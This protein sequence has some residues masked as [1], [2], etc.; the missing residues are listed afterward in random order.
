MRPISDLHYR[1]PIRP[2]APIERT[3][4]IEPPGSGRLHSFELRRRI[5]GAGEWSEAEIGGAAAQGIGSPRLGM[6]DVAAG[7]AQPSRGGGD[8]GGQ[9][10]EGEEAGHG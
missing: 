7:H 9:Q 1:E 4:T 3:I 2:F 10:Q 5:R 8:Q 6:A